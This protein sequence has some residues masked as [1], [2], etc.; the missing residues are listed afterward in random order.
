MPRRKQSFFE[1]L[2]GAVNVDYDD[3]FDDETTHTI[4]NLTT[5]D[6]DEEDDELDADPQDDT[7]HETDDETQADWMEEES[8]GQLGVDVY[9]T[10]DDII[11]KTMVAGVRPDDLDISITRD[12][13]TI[14][15]KREETHSIPEEQYFQRELYWGVFSRTILLPAEVEVEEAEA[16][17]RHGLLIIRLPKINK[18]KQT[19]LKV[20]SA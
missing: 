11:V 14:K 3:D 6:P 17:E 16:V 10:R 5:D 4:R 20:K 7:Y 15:G 8:E 12:I 18:D 9:Q 19:R 1:R 2:T 13:V